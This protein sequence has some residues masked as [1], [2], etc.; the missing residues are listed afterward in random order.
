MVNWGWSL[1]FDQLRRKNREAWKEIWKSRVKVTGDDRAQKYLDACLYY[2]YSSAHRSCRTSIGPFG[3]SQVLNYYG[4]VFWDGDTYMFPALLITSPDTAKMMVDYRFRH[5]EAARRRAQAFGYK[6]VMYPWQ[7]D[8]KG[9]EG[10]ASFVDCA[11]LEQHINL[12]VAEAMWRYYLATGD[13]EFA[14]KKAWP[15]MKGVAEWV[16]TRVEKTARGY[17]VRDI[18][19]IVEGEHVNNPCY[20]NVLSAAALRDA[21][22]CAKVAGEKPGPRWA[23]IARNMFIPRGPAPDDSVV[24]GEILYNHDGGAKV[25]GA[26]MYMV[27]F[28]YDLPFDKELLKR[29]FDHY[30]ALPVKTLSMGLAYVVGEAAFVGDRKAAREAFNKVIRHLSEPVWGMGTEYSTAKTTC[31]VTTQGAMIEVAL[32]GFTGIRFEP[33]NWTKYKACL[34]EGWEK[35]EVDQIWLGGKAYSLTAV[36]GQK[37]ELK[38]ID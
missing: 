17:E 34:P 15:V 11:W 33:G 23:G 37:A 25:P 29:S 16:E 7:S 31:F 18:M 21:A 30:Y 36:N 32:M 28:P 1:G 3:M 27:G 12:S 35:I 9:F 24:K 22:A 4:H 5:L 10:T 20:V 2:L 38:L 19:G 6:G 26:G 14:R 13:E 8:T